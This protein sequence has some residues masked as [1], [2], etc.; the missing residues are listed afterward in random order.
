MIDK[1]RSIEKV[2]ENLDTKKYTIP[3]N[4]PY[5]EA[6]RLFKEPEVADPEKLD[7]TTIDSG[8]NLTS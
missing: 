1:H 4:W 7:V 3:E 6:R 8:P 2:L 5:Q